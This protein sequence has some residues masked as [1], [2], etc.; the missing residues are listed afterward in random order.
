MSGWIQAAMQ[1]NTT[2]MRLTENKMRQMVDTGFK[3]FVSQLVARTI[4]RAK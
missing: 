3:C 4:F 1:Q 2:F